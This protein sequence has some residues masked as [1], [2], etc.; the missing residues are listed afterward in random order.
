ME[1]HTPSI[2]DKY[3]PIPQ[4]ESLPDEEK[5]LLRNG[6][7]CVRAYPV[8]SPYI[9]NIYREQAEVIGEGHQALI[10]G[11]EKV[12]KKLYIKE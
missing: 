7:F 10:I 8:E 2:F 12:Y 11:D 3:K 4:G 9:S 6:Y 5:D 1:N